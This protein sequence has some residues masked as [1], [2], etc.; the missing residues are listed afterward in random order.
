[1]STFLRV[2]AENC[3]VRV[4]FPLFEFNVTPLPVKN[5]KFPADDVWKNS[6]SDPTLQG[7]EALVWIEQV[8]FP[9][10]LK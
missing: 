5:N 7:T 1:M 3:P 2:A 8:T 6:N 10:A 4:I 9:P